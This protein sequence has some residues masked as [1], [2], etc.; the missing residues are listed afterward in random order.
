MYS[1][2]RT[3]SFEFPM[4]KVHKD[5]IAGPI[6]DRNPILKQLFNKQL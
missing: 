5:S 1:I 2:V 6:F 4:S 3:N